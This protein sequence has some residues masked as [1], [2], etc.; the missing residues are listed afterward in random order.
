MRT[1]TKNEIV[2]PDGLYASAS[3]SELVY[4]RRLAN[5][6][7]AA[8]RAEGR[9]NEADIMRLLA[10]IWVAIISSAFLFKPEMVRST[11]TPGLLTFLALVIVALTIIMLTP[12]YKRKQ[13]ATIDALTTPP[14]AKARTKVSN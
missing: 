12:T 14:A 6:I 9:K 11:P 7:V 1:Y 8:N 3:P 13:Q 5:S 10:Y 2:N 4:Q